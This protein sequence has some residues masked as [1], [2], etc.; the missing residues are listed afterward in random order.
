MKVKSSSGVVHEYD[1]T[2][3]RKPGEGITLPSRFYQE[4][5]IDKVLEKSSLLPIDRAIVKSYVKNNGKK[6][7]II[8]DVGISRSLIHQKLKSHHIQRVIKRV[9]R[10][11]GL[12]MPSI[13]KVVRYV[14]MRQGDYHYDFNRLRAIDMFLELTGQK[15]PKRIE[16]SGQMEVVDNSEKKQVIMQLVQILKASKDES[17]QPKN[18]GMSGGTS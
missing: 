6:V 16:H 7:A 12:D 9:F 11:I 3:G 5:K 17:L 8:K 13:L 15:V 2:S 10:K 18:R 1:Y 14:M 4:K